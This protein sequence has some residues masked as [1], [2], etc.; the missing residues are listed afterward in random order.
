MS[1]KRRPDWRVTFAN[2]EKHLRGAQRSI[3]RYTKVSP[4]TSVAKLDAKARKY[5]VRAKLVRPIPDVAA[6]SVQDALSNFRFALDQL[7]NALG[8]RAFPIT[9]QETDFYMH[10]D[11]GKLDRRSGAAQLNGVEPDVFATVE[12]L[13]PYNF[14]PAAP[15]QN[16]LAV[17]NA[18]RNRAHRKLHVFLPG[19]SSFGFPVPGMLGDKRDPAA[20]WVEVPGGGWMFRAKFTL[21]SGPIL[22][23]GAELASIEND[24]SGYKPQMDVSFHGP[25]VVA[26]DERA[27]VIDTLG[28][29]RDFILGEVF[30]ALEPFVG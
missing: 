19:A 10:P 17:L 5:V 20:P 25:F 22:E 18:L 29:I 7:I 27:P 14:S 26:L 11:A 1:P 6:T 21:A 16:P 12:W 9:A 2:G 23:D 30:P 28:L 4:Y 3:E 8:G 24:P 13:Q 15:K